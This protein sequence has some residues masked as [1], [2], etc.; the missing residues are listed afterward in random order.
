VNESILMP[1]GTR[2]SRGKGHEKI[3]FG[4]QI[5]GQS[6]TRPKTNLEIWRRHHS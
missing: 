5:K 3:N 6:Y 2:C 1:S 4:G